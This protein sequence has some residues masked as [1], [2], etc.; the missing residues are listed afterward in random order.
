MPNYHSFR[1]QDPIRVFSSPEMAHSERPLLPSFGEFVSAEQMSEAALLECDARTPP[2][3]QRLAKIAQ[4]SRLELVRIKT[5]LC[6]ETAERFRL[7]EILRLKQAELQAMQD[8]SPLG[9]FL[10][11]PAGE[12]TFCN[13]VLEQITGLTSQ[14]L[15]GSGWV[16]A[17]HSDDSD[18]VLEKWRA[19]LH[20][21]QEYSSVHRLLRPDGQT[22]WVR[23]KAAPKKD[24]PAI[25]GY[26]GMVE[27]VSPLKE[28]EKERQHYEVKLRHAQK[29]ES[30][31]Q[32]AAGIAHEINTP[33]QYV[34]DNVRF[35]RDA[36]GDIKKILEPLRALLSQDKDLP[37]APE[38]FAPIR[39]LAAEHDLDYL[40][41]E[42]PQAV[43]QSLEGIGRVSKIV[44]AMKEF[45]HPGA[46]EKTALDLN[47][48]IETTITVARNEWRY[49]ADL[50][51]GLDP[52]LPPVPCLPGEF[53]QVILNLIV[54]A[55]HA[56]ADAVGS[57]SGKKGLITI[58]TRQNGDW[59]EVRIKDSGAG[60][61][62]KIRH[63][64]FEPFFTTKAVGKGT[65]QGLAIAH[66][67]VVEKHGGT[68]HFESEAG[69]GTTFIIRLPAG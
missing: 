60:I 53:N 19:A 54:N 4:E 31:G 24:G 69:Q 12:L 63:R 35:L 21:H 61:P 34:G 55:A 16:R 42:V 65:G 26:A 50:E 40:M 68:I 38:E 56:I 47:K 67:V 20:S 45:S 59:I 66:S 15:H 3:V 37:I 36:F 28:A 25:I 7:E 6:E 2:S 18:G 51:T 5:A 44:Q 62:E 23:V 33:T 10:T 1:Y 58:S 32:L 41:D 52:D 27:D 64:I 39:L 22:V 49:V 13:K 43:Q 29:M 48:A 46:T 9:L 30:I 14:T 57:E 8:V 11:D 17:L